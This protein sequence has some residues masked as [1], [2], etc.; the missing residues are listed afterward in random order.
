MA[1]DVALE[2]CFGLALA[3]AGETDIAE[4]KQGLAVHPLRI[5]RCELVLVTARWE[6]G[7]DGMS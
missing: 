2:P 5:I 3:G 7:A 4:L 1:D 6:A